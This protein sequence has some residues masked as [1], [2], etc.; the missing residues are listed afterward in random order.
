MGLHRPL[1]PPQL[2]IRTPSRKEA[3]SRP[4]QP[5]LM[6]CLH[7]PA[8]CP[9]PGARTPGGRGHAG[10]ATKSPLKPRGVPIP[11]WTPQLGPGHPNQDGGNN[12]SQSLT[13][14][15]SD[16]AAP[17]SGGRGRPAP[18]SG[19]AGETSEFPG[20]RRPLSWKDGMLLQPGPVGDPPGGELTH[21]SH[22]HMGSSTRRP[23]KP[24][25]QPSSI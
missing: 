1:Q 23:Q 16:P 4:E 17:S 5:S 12:W 2:P 7:F 6:L 21:T 15:E 20:P 25:T 9:Q 13:A 24:Q 8:H 18:E 3:S 11:T 14:P 22:Q 10:L 19:L